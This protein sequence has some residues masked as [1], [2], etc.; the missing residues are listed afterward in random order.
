MKIIKQRLIDDG[1]LL[2]AVIIASCLYFVLNVP[3]EVVNVVKI[4]IDDH[5]P[6]LP[7]FAIP[8]LLFLPWFWAVIFYVWYKDNSFKQLAYSV[9]IINLVASVVYIMFQTYIPRD[10][11]I[12]N[13]LFSGILGFIY[14]NDQAYN[15]FPSLHS[16]L[17]ATV[18]TFFVI[19]K[20]RFAVPTFLMALLIVISTLFTK[21]HFILDAV[22]GITLGVI[23]TSFVFWF[24]DKRN[25][26]V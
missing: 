16:G 15:G 7:V 13:D 5:I 11:I 6:R 10:V 24:C 9:I 4:F 2:L 8:Y 21:Q 14:D 17:S 22:S 23:I 1:M 3:H 12:S 18:A 25:K 19:K 26:A 20:S